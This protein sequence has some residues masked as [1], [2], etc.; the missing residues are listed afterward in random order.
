[1]PKRQYSLKRKE[2]VFDL[3]VFRNYFAVAFKCC[4][5][6]R[7]KRFELFP[8]GTFDR[9]GVAK[10]LRN[11]RIF[12]F[13]SISFDMPI[14]MAAMQGMNCQELKMVCDTIIN[15]RLIYF[16]TYERFGINKPPIF[17]DHVDLMNV[18]PGSPNNSMG[19]KSS[20]EW[21]SL[22]L[23]GGRLHT[24][25]I[26][27]MP[28]DVHVELNKGQIERVRG[29]HVNDLDVTID[30]LSDLRTQIELRAIMSDEYGVDLRSKSDAQ[31]AEAVIKAEV[32]R[33][34]GNTV[35][36][37]KI[38]PGRFHYHPPAF[39]EYKTEVLQ[40]LL[41][42]VREAKFTIGHDGKVYEPPEIE[43][44]KIPLG[45][46]TYTFGIGGLHS[47]EKRVAYVPDGTFTLRD[48]DVT[49][50]YPRTILN[51]GLFPKQLGMYFPKVYDRIVVRRVAAKDAGDKNTAETL[52][53]VLN[54]TFGK[55]GQGTSILYAPNLLIQT[56]I[57]G[58]L[59]ILMLIERLELAGITVIS[60]NTDGIVSKVPK[61]LEARFFWICHDWEVDTGYGTEEVEYSAIYSRDV[62]NYIALYKEKDKVT[63]EIKTKA[64][65]KGA[66]GERG[67]GLSGAAG[68]KHNPDAEICS[69]AVTEY[70]KNGTPMET[71]I[72]ECE[73]FRKFV[74]V[75]RV[76]GGAV[77]GDEYIGKVVRWYQ[78]VGMTDCLRYE[79][80]GN[81]VPSSDGA[82]PAMVLPDE[83]PDD[84]DYQWYINEAYAILA[85]IGAS[86]GDPAL[87]GRTGIMLATA[88]EQKTVHRVKLPSGVAM[89]G[90]ELSNVRS[91]WREFLTMPSGLRLC[92][93]CA[94]CVD[95]DEL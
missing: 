30:L 7:W 49:S 45:I 78:A 77:L 69:I 19:G 93:K 50:Y 5:T 75:R 86:E 34:S 70:L 43:S 64:K 29:Y 84:I 16:K 9:A 80:N 73:D 56:T 94:K 63:G 18:S 79:T 74:I 61:E 82:K 68:Q 31:I 62:N 76:K 72:E 20:G 42:T 53:I 57:T 25:K 58:Q 4:E 38:V 2:A 21:P 12:G 89:C 55:L 92:S 60:A 51:T 15:E 33:M 71:T 81:K 85:D 52:K 28:V 87:A 6:G 27:E 46:Q 40:N 88:P 90:K 59:A 66:Y 41:R 17:V 37:P 54:G 35:A 95:E 10:V 13:N 83:L 91:K 23:Y 67:P 22:K 8:G 1:M 39:V 47:T 48:R 65:R 24:K 44:M 36:K 14:L 26:Q 32:E 3:E 11:F